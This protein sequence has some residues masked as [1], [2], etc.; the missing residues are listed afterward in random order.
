[1]KKLFILLPIILLFACKKHDVCCYYEAY[2]IT[3]KQDVNTESCKTNLSKK[4]YEAFMNGE[5]NLSL[6]NYNNRD[7][8]YVTNSKYSCK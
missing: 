3:N 7:I 1:M 4:E 2:D 8:R 6:T 5:D